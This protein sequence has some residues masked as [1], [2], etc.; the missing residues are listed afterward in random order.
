MTNHLLKRGTRYYIRRKIPLDLIS[1]YRGRKEIVKA[2]GTSEPAKARERVREESYRLDQEFAALRQP[3]GDVPQ[4]V[5]LRELILDPVTS[6]SVPTGRTAK[7]DPR[8]PGSYVICDCDGEQVAVLWP[9]D[10]DDAYHKQRLKHARTFAH[11]V[12]IARASGTPSAL[13][14]SVPPQIASSETRGGAS[15]GHLAA[16]VEKWAGERKPESR[17]VRKAE[18]IVERFYSHVGRV[19]VAGITRAHVIAFK[20]KL[21]ETGQTPV[22]TNK[23]LELL[24]TLL[25]YAKDNLLV[26]ENAA[27][28]V[29]VQVKGTVRGKTRISFD[30]PA[31][32]AIF[33]SPVYT[34]N[35]RPV[36]GAGE[37]AYWLPLLG[38]FTG[39]R[40]EE[41]AQLRPDDIYTE[42]Y[43]TS[44]SS[45]KSSAVLR[46]TDAGDGQTVKNAG[47]V[48]RIPI[49]PELLERGFVEY[50]HAQ[51]GKPRIFSA[52]VANKHGEES[53][54]WSKWFGKY[55]R[56]VCKITDSR[57]VYHSFRH[58][59]KDMCRDSGV[60][61]EVADA[62]Q[63]HNDGD[64]SGGYGAEFYPLRPLVEAMGR[65]R[66]PGLTLPAPPP[67]LPVA[68]PQTL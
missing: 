2:L 51:R 40:L 15:S 8:R 38:L 67:S 4:T 37:A 66:V 35:L 54:Q 12:L 13:T 63:G 61:K 47:S 22:N 64:A 41:L 21:L 57:M 1:H 19:P 28:R 45:V 46:I 14:A 24:G 5:E 29:R 39:A 30:V 52:L 60:P 3:T 50:V 32:T 33:S 62:L 20:D 17:T 56:G 53:A 23:Q 59:F 6:E 42:S 36:G 43:H 68:D 65:I 48:R 26:S 9:K 11:G 58:G 10:A 44:N 55:L 18:L 16:L 34:R 31:L 49:H 25:N 27:H 7:V